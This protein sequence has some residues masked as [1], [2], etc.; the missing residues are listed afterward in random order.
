MHDDRPDSIAEAGPE[1]DLSRLALAHGEGRR[2][3]LPVGTIRLTHGGEPLEAELEEGVARLEVSRTTS[4]WAFRLR[5]A[6]V[7]RGRCVRCLEPAERRIEVEAREVHQPGGEDEE[8]ASP[9]VTD[10]VLDAGRWARDA[11]ALALPAQFL[12]R[13]DCAGL[14]PDCGVPLNEFAPGEHVHERPRDPRFAA[15]DKLRGEI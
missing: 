6:A 11:L 1:V 5:Y 14:C 7:G 12:C 9:Y 13:D 15:L 3:E 2:I 4:G 10:L 8:L